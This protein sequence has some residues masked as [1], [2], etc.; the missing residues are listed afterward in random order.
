MP[1]YKLLLECVLWN[2]TARIELGD[3]GRKYVTKG[4]VTEQGIIQFLMNQI[5][6]EGCLDVRDSL[7]KEN[8]LLEAPFSYSRKRGSVVIRNPQFEG[9]DREVRVYCKGAPEILLENASKVVIQSGE[10]VSIFDQAEI[11]KEL[12]LEEGNHLDVLQSTVKMFASKA[13]RLL[14]IGYRD[15]SMERFLDLKG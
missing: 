11:P 4:N 3:S 7:K 14:V 8:I 10:I 5:G 1:A 9:T 6:G 2:S 12:T 13:F 15:M